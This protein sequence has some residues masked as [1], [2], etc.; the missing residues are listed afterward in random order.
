[1]SS[2]VARRFAGALFTKS[3]RWAVVWLGRLTVVAAVSYPALLLAV[4]LALAYIGER[5]WVTAVALYV[6]RFAFGAPLPVLVAL[7]LWF[8]KRELLWTQLVALLLLVFPLMGLSLPWFTSRSDTP[9][10]R[11]MS[12]NADSG[13]AGIPEIGRAI[14]AI[15]PDVVLLQE[16]ERQRQTFELEIRK[17]YPHVESSTQFVIGSRFPILE[18]TDPER[19]P[20]WGRMRSPR[21]MRY[22]I[23][24]PGGDVAVYSVHP[25][26]PRG[27]LQLHRFRGAFGALRRGDL[28][29]GDP[30]KDVGENTGLRQLQVEAI[31]QLAEREALPVVIAGDTNLPSL[32]PLFRKNL[33]RYQDGFEAASSGFG[34]TY[35][36]KYPWMR[37]DRILASD[38]LRFLAFHT[39]C[40]DLSDHLCVYADLQH[41]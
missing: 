32:S 26:S 22:S 15:S 5:W 39:D 10:F 33:G 38:A 8:R 21:F 31:A 11:V 29:A 20:Y 25:A 6:P 7:L 30:A 12:F 13:Y 35:P 9:V 34:Y 3:I 36:E 24:T 23:R 28:F 4:A 14:R 41:R 18:S 40:P 1:M 19:L 37:I 17:L 2:S 16:A 27:V